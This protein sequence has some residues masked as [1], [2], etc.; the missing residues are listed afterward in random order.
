ML[1]RKLGRELWKQKTQFFAIF[2]MSFLGLL[3]YVGMDAESSGAWASAQE[4]YESCAL[5]DFWVQ[6]A[7]FSQDDAELIESLP[8]VRTV[9]RCLTVDAKAEGIIGK[10]G[11][12][13]E[14][15][16]Y[17]LEENNVSMPYVVQ[18]EAFDENKKG[19]W[20]DEQFAK[21]QKLEPGDELTVKSGD[22]KLT[23]KILGTV[24]S[25]EHVYYTSK[26]GEMVP[27]YGTF[28]YAFLPGDCYLMMC[29]EHKPENAGFYNML[30][31]DTFDA[32]TEDDNVSAAMKDQLKQMLGMDDLLVV[33]RKE[34]ASY[35]T[36]LAEM[37]QHRTMSVMFP[38]IFMLIAV[39]GI[40]TTMTRMAANERTQIGT[41]KAL[42]FSN[43]R[44]LVHYV[45]F[46][47][48][49]C[50]AGS[51]LGAIV[52]AKWFP[53]LIL[54]SMTQ[55]YLLPQ[56]N[57]RFALRDLIAIVVVTAIA[58]LVSLFAC[59]KELR[60]M[61][62][63]TLRPKSPK[64]VKPSA[65]ERTAL[66][67]AMGF[68]SQWNIRDVRKNKLRTLMGVIGVAGSMMLLIC[69]FGCRDSMNYMPK[70]MFEK[71][72]LNERTIVFEPGT[73]AFTVGEYA[74]KYGGQQ[75][76][77]AS[78]ELVGNEGTKEQKV[79][80][81]TLT[82]VDSG[83]MMHFQDYDQ[84]EIRLAGKDVLISTKMAELLDVQPGEIVRFKIVGDDK[85]YRVRVT[86]CNRTPTGQGI[87]MS[88]ERFRELGCDF[89]P[90][91]VLT[92]YS[93][94]D[95]L[96]DE[97]EIQAVQDT[98][99]R[100]Q[101]MLDSLSIMN[102]MIVLMISVAVMLGLV[103]LYNL[104]EL[105]F[106]EK[107]REYTTLKVLGLQERVIRGMILT[108]NLIV[109]VIGVIAGIP[110]GRAFTHAMFSDMG[111]TQDMV[112]VITV[113]SYLTAAAGAIVIALTAGLMMSGRIK[114]MN[115]V[116]ALKSNE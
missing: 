28:G 77:T 47:F 15:T 37:E 31:V 21:R 113:N 103:V 108:Q 59:R 23:F 104:S 44:V 9:Q 12:E 82:V 42:G 83:G 75:I 24:M 11:E 67:K 40:T 95:D 68:V 76:Q 101:E 22:E 46:G 97:D 60:G 36:F 39:L 93:L 41:M 1:L 33:D 6:G 43:Q 92:N 58:T 56:W 52:G 26:Q 72:N 71:L 5:A 111:E 100:Q 50:L 78:V 96:V 4:Y 19:F 51:A 115:M 16:L 89:E 102:T 91:Q 66:W 87:T 86:G 10:G 62:A 34:N 20:L 25:P 88:T 99:T 84:N 18:G 38:A 69:A 74:R 57:I 98:E 110:L 53:A 61:P 107:V 63:Q 14:M 114:R 106:V 79:K 2:M 70:Q 94:P 73:D 80:S 65:F 54:G 90:N 29:G 32:Y 35:S 48:V 3:I 30:K 109:G 85:V 45:S 105:S 17:F 55:M 13:A 27:D 64:A 112:E 49:V 116:D 8:E 81:A 7:C